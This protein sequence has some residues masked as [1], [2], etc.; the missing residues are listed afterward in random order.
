[1]V[2]KS[3]KPVATGIQLT[4][5]DEPFRQDPYPILADLRERDPTHRDT[6]L[7]RVFLTRHDQV[8]DV[9]RSKTM[10]VDARKARDDSF[11]AM[12]LRPNEEQPSMLGMD[13][14][15]HRRLRIGVDHLPAS[16]GGP[17]RQHRG[18]QSIGPGHR[19]KGE[20]ARGQAG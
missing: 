1:M 19:A 13:D 20:S 3:D 9:L 5:L 10:W 4:P 14:P 2:A 12:F 17:G 15:D 18:F 16:G 7:H 6:E 8:H 11:H